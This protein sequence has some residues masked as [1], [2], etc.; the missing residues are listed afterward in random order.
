RPRPRPPQELDEARRWE[1]VHDLRPLEGDVLRWGG[2][3]LPNHPPYNAGAF[4][5]E[6]TFSHCHPLVPPRATLRT[7][8]YHPAVGP[9]G[10]LC[11][12]LTCAPR[13]RPSMRALHGGC[14]GGGGLWE[15]VGGSPDAPI[16]LQDLQQ[17][18]DRPDPRWALRPDLARELR[19]EPE[20]FQQRAEEH[21]RR[22]AE[23]RP[24]PPEP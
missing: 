4:R 1:G 2:L 23:R 24:D 22:H 8:I 11:Q 14:W 6:L 18:L 20:V 3:L 19:E 16:V 21:T 10:R 5:F 13:W 15:A 17:L 9:D 7:P 12:P